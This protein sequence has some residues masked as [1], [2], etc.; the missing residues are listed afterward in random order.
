[1]VF[2]VRKG[3]SKGTKMIPFRSGHSQQFKIASISRPMME[4]LE[5]RRLLSAV[6]HVTAVAAD[7]RGLAT[8]TFDTDLNAA[9]V[10]SSSAAIYTAGADATLGTA[11]DVAAA[12]TVSYTASLKTVTLSANLTPDTPYRIVLD[13][14]QIQSTDG[15][16]LDGEFNGAA[17]PS[18]DGTPGGNFDI[19]TAAN[20]DVARF[21]TVAGWI[22]VQLDTQQTPQ[23]VKNFIAY[24]NA[25]DWD[26]TFFHRSV[27]NFIVQGGGF[28][29]NAGTGAI[30]AVPSLGPVVNE[31]GVSNTRGTIAMAKLSGDPNSATNQWFFNTADNSSNLDAQNGGFTAFGSITN[32]SGLNTMDAISAL[33][34]VNVGGAFTNLPVVDAQAI[35]DRGHQ[36]DPATDLVSISRVAM[37]MGVQGTHVAPAA[38]AV[39]ADDS[40]SQVRLFSSDGQNAGGFTAYPGFDGSVRL[41]MADFT[42]DGVADIVTG[43]GP[44]G[45]HV[46]IFDGVTH[47]PIAG[48]LGSFLAFPGPGTPADATYFSG[49]FTGGVYVAA[50]DVNADGTPDLIVS[51]DAGA[52]AHVKVFSGADG[53]LLQSFFAYD[54]FDGGVRV[55]AGDIN[56]DGHADIITGAASYAPHVKAFSGADHTL[57]ASFFAYDN[58]P[59]GVYVAAGDTNGDG[60]AEIITGTSYGPPNVK[61][62]N[63]DATPVASFFAYGVGF[64]GGVRVGTAD[65]NSD[66]KADILTATGPGAGHVKGFDVSTLTELESFIADATDTGGLYIAGSAA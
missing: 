27:P 20:N 26:G 31:P 62:F 33:P 21:S 12:E 6:P 18:G 28:K 35:A 9:T 2:P 46:K 10:D 32:Q 64:W 63:A 3:T 54:G 13:A 50:G 5:P 42:G 55:A 1:M 51:A 41:A 15:T 57:L 65:L 7:N 8:L 49:S 30:D 53:T 43:T 4:L 60:H 52:G 47:Q 59:Y 38:Q 29:Y 39:A 19:T 25:G 61:V 66:G 34:T 56:G 24:A 16:K 48:P 17:Q 23:T 44:G 37:L 45:S 40:G 58:Y 36:V 11:D 14:S 22:D